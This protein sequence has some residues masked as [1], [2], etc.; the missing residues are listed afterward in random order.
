MTTTFRSWTPLQIV[1]HKIDSELL[2]FFFINGPMSIL[3]ALAAYQQYIPLQLKPE[4]ANTE[5]IGTVSAKG[6]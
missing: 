3:Q 4:A 1:A 5:T 6:C 2:G